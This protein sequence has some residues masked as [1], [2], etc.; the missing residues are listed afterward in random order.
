MK[1]ALIGLAVTVLLGG[2]ALHSQPIVHQP[3][4]ARSQPTPA[5]M[6][7]NGSIFQASASRPLFEDRKPSQVGDTLT[8][9]IQERSSSSSSEESSNEQKTSF[10]NTINA[11]L[12]FPY[13]PG[14][15]RRKLAGANIDADGNNTFETTA[16]SDTSSSFNTSITVTVIEV[17]PNGN[18]LVSGE[19]QMRINNNSEFIRMSGVVNPRDLQAGNVVPSTKVADARFEKQME[20][21]QRSFINPGWLSRFFMS[22]LPF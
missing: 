9:N 8:I 22:V 14:S 12:R 3:M 5:A 20:G 1:H 19:K 2:C 6:P 10:N 4:T 11:G 16:D 17:L 13:L 18:L 15:L 7:S 21:V